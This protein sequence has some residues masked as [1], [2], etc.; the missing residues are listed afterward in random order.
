MNHLSDSQISVYEEPVHE[1]IRK[2]IKLEFLFN[3]IHYFK[4][5]EDSYDN[6]ISLLSMSNLYEIL[7]RSDIKSE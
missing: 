5:K 1:R 2:L 6:Y 4:N 7:V 3:Q